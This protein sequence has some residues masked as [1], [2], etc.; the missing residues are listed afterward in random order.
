MRLS[1][2]PRRRRAGASGRLFL[3]VV[4]ILIAL[5]AWAVYVA[6]RYPTA[7]PLTSTS[8]MLQRIGHSHTQ[9]TH[10]VAGF[11]PYWQADDT[12][13]VP[14][15]QLSQVIFFSLTA[16]Q[17]GQIVTQKDGKPEPGWAG[18]N[19]PS[20]RNGVARSQIAGTRALLSVSQQ[21]GVQ[22]GAFLDDTAAQQALIATISTAVA[23]NNLDGLNLDFEFTGSSTPAHRDVFTGFAR[24]LVSAVHSRVPGS[25]LSIDL[26]PISARTPGLYDV[27]ALAQVFDRI[28][29]M[30]YDYYTP[31]SDVA[32]PDAPI[33]GRDERGYFFDVSTT[34]DDYQKV[35]PAAKLLMGVP[36]Y[37]YDWPVDDNSKTL[38]LVLPQ[39][40]AHGFAE[41]VSYR[42]MKTDP[43]YSGSNCHW[44]DIAQ[45]TWCG[46]TDPKTNVQR[47]AWLEDDR[48][49]QAKLS[50]AKQRQLAG[51]ALWTL[52]YAGPDPQ[53]WSL[54]KSQFASS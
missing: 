34:Y 18:W 7:S 4:V 36:Y 40:D 33:S 13:F 27:P 42:R 12:A 8:Y 49:I 2:A 14:L 39:D 25:E 44:D 9:L 51:V 16:D 48:S 30:S 6:R 24:S 29:V 3:P 11:L 22:L 31:G 26:P 17:H 54:L 43:N 41:A 32:G 50:F 15:D 53:P 46:Y 21:D 19:A 52:G 47:R 10:E 38:P 23:D 37:G 45:Q 5:A 20:E 1:P 35:V 28:I